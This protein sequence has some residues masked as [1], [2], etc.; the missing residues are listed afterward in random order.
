MSFF[1]SQ[2]G[3]PTGLLGQLVGTIMAYQNRERNHWAVALLDIQAGD[4]VL[5]IGFGPGLAIQEAARLASNGLFAGVD[6]SE[7]MLRQ[8]HRRSAAAVRAG[9]VDLRLG[10]AMALP[11][12]DGAFDKAFATNSLHHWPDP[13]AGLRELRRVLKPGGLVAIIEQPRG[14]ATDAQVQALAD[15]RAAQLAE[16]GF[17]EMR[18]EF[19]PMRPAASVGVLG[20]R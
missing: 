11:F 16:A 10:S 6:T 12:P 13:A 19:K 15:Q 1:T 20:I 3:H 18:L 17:R 14:S 4:H 8:A 2:F 7:V 5:E 9:R